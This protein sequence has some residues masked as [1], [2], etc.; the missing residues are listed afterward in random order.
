MELRHLRYFAAAAEEENISRA[1]S[2]LHISQPGISRH[3]RNL[4]DEIGFPLFHRKGK[5]VQLTVAG[6]ILFREARHIL[7]SIESAVQ[8]A[9]ASLGSRGDIS[10]GFVPLGTMKI[11]SR[12]LNAFRD[13][14]P[15]V[16]VTLHDLSAEEMLPMI[17]Q[18]KL[19]IALTLPPRKLPPGL[20]M[21]ELA[22]YP[23]CV[24]VGTRHPLA[25]EKSVSLDQMAS[26][27][28]A[29]LK[30]KDYP[31]Y[32]EYVGRL[33]AAVGLKPHISSEHDSA[34]TMMA[35][36]EGGQEYTL[37]PSSVRNAA[38]PRL[39][40]LKLRPALDPWVYVALWRKD[41]ETESI[42]AF[43]A[44]AESSKTAVKEAE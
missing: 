19:H 27:P 43:I 29:A 41:S 22:R 16:Q 31:L 2:K 10:V 36:V 3:I 40:L 21:K 13:Q 18:E 17:V 24:A 14:Y 9:R 11:L 12:A 8:K 23:A 5:S 28:L 33:F 20:C 7:E 44:G 1:A 6:K 15:G 32:H 26:E 35:A 25:K 39:K 38:G 37:L 34:T 42:R 30:R 4:E